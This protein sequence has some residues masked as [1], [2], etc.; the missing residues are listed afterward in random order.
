MKN[1]NK[2]ELEKHWAT[3]AAKKRR[4]VKSANKKPTP[5]AISAR[6]GELIQAA[7][8]PEPQ[9]VEGKN[10]VLEASWDKRGAAG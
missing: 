2:R 9:L 8:L 1:K 4:A 3:E 10:P 7:P 6:T 5:P